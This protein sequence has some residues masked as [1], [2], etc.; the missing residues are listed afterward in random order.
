MPK[1]FP[2][3][4]THTI[5]VRSQPLHCHSHE[6]AKF[7]ELHI[8]FISC[9]P[10]CS[11]TCFPFHLK[12]LARSPMTYGWLSAR[13]SSLSTILNLPAK[14]DAPFLTFMMLPSP[15]LPLASPVKAH[16]SQPYFKQTTHKSTAHIFHYFPD[17][18]QMPLG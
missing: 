4:H 1:S 12:L 16:P 9:L 18:N 13:H 6:T 10:T 8:V 17:C 7:L 3:K 15:G 5:L 14:S 2:I 11:S